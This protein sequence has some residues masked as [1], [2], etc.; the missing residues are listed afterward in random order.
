MTVI[1]KDMA[2]PSE[3]MWG[4]LARDIM[5]AFDM[6]LKTPN[7]I[8]K[9]LT[10][11]GRAIPDWLEQEFQGTGQDSVLSKGTRCTLIWKAMHAAVELS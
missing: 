1:W 9:H 2:E 8:R 11:L 6:N 7:G 10:L 3:A 4:G 5:M